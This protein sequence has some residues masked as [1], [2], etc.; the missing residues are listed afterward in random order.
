MKCEEIFEALSE[1]IDEEIAA[2][3]CSEIEAHLEHCYNCRV[4]VDTL[5]KTVALYH[6]VPEEN[7]PDEIRLRLHKIIRLEIEE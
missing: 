4:V 5:K 6:A 7:L 3:K 2:Q 1:Y